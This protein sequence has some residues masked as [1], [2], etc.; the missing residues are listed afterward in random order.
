MSAHNGGCLCGNVRYKVTGNPEI[1]AACHCRYRQ[2]RTGLAF[3]ALAY[4]NNV[5]F[6]ITLRKVKKFNFTSESGNQWET[7]FCDNCATS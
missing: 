2:L 4:F 6:E 1:S 5:N 3:G 7:F